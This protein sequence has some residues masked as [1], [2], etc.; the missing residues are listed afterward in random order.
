MDLPYW[1]TSEH[2]TVPMDGQLVRIEKDCI[3]SWPCVHR[4]TN[5]LDAV[6][7]WQLLQQ[8][9]TLEQEQPD[10]WAHFQQYQGFTHFA[11]TLIDAL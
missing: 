9:P 8:Q 10:L 4:N 11:G 5:R 3:E 6:D 7:I 1:P 2:W